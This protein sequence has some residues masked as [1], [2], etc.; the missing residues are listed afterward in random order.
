MKCV[1]LMLLTVSLGVFGII[2][3][4]QASTNLIIYH[5]KSDILNTAPLTST[6]TFDEF[7]SETVFCC[8]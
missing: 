6:E 2:L 3:S 8:P 7:S 1:A 4:G 5:S